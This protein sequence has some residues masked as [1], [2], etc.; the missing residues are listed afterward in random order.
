MNHLIMLNSQLKAVSIAVLLE[1]VGIAAE[2]IVSDALK[3]VAN[4]PTIAGKQILEEVV[5]FHALATQLPPE[6]PFDQI[7]AEITKKLSKYN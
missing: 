6:L 2:F 7:R 4:M 3:E 5:F 1:Y